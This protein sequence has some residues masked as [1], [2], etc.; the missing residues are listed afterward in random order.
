MK[1]L[2]GFIILLVILFITYTYRNDI[3][4]YV[5]DNYI[6]KKDIF[7]PEAN[8]YKKNDDFLF[9]KNTTNFFPNNKQEL[10]N[11]F[12]TILNSG[13][14]NFTFYCGDEYSTCNEDVINLTKENSKNLSYINNYV[15]PYNSYSSIGVTINKLGKI[16]VTIHKLYSSSDIFVLDKYIATLYKNLVN[17]KM[18]DKQKIKVI[19][20][21]I[22]NNSIYDQTWVTTTSSNRLYK[23]NTAYGPLLEHNGLCGG[24]TDAMALFLEKM[25]IKNYKIASEKHIWN[26]VYVDGSWKHLDL[27]WDD[28]ITNTGANILQYDYYLINTIQLQ[29]KKDKDHTYSKDAYLEA[30]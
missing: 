22:I 6:Y 20:D 3:S 21:Y 28:P 16:N 10:Y 29:N 11:V 27:T 25:H 12:Y 26:Y 14:T 2:L 1:K 19:H 18:T 24:Y 17:D 23:S 30:K 7:V 9:V 8:Q 15:S 4:K 13:W 5:M